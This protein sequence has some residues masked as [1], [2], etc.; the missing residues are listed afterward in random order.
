MKGDEDPWSFGVEGYAL[1]AGGLGFEFREHGRG[2][3][4]GRLRREPQLQGIG[5]ENCSTVQTLTGV[6]SSVE[7]V[8]R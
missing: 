1:C 4:A 2:A 6:D 8:L 3:H 5:C 7:F